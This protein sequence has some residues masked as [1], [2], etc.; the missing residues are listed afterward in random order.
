[1]EF[2]GGYQREAFREVETHLVAEY[3]TGAGAGAVGL[4]RAVIQDMLQQVEVLFHG[5]GFVRPIARLCA[6]M[7]ASKVSKKYVILFLL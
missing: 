2:F 3:R 6:A 4:V 7:S 5:V 1:M